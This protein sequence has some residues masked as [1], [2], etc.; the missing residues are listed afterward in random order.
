MRSAL[1]VGLFWGSISVA[2][3]ALLALPALGDEPAAEAQ[4]TSTGVAGIWASR[5]QTVAQ[6]IPELADRQRALGQGLA[7]VAFQGGVQLNSA[8]GFGEIPT[9]RYGLT[10]QLELNLLGARYVVTEDGRYI[11]GF[12]VRGELHDLAY[13]RNTTLNDN[14][15]VLRPSAFFEFRDRL[16][17]HVSLNGEIGYVVTVQGGNNAPDGT[18]ITAGSRIPES[19][20]PLDLEVQWSPLTLFSFV[21]KVGYLEDTATPPYAGAPASDAY[22]SVAAI[23][24]MSRFDVRLYYQANWFANPALG[25]V[26]EFGASAAVRL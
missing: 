24:N 5:S 4:P 11:P 21:G 6:Y 3:S 19:M 14:Y 7:E 23:Y 25:F 15:A 18:P 16:P 10:D 20:A 26:P 1:A 22:F 12:S 17:W 8:L 9:L 2:V 13:Q